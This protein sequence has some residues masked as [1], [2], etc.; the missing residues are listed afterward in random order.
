MSVDALETLRSEC[1]RNSCACVD[2]LISSDTIVYDN[3][4]F[5]EKTLQI[6]RPVS[7]PEMRFQLRT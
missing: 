5:P 2:F 1:T 6:S 3:F 4:L 7:A